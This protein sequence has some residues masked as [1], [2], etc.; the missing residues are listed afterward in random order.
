[1][2]SAAHSRVIFGPDRRLTAVMFAGA[3]L[4]ALA[5]WA[6]AD[7]AGRLLA[8]G[9]ATVLAAYAVTDLLFWPRLCADSTGIV[10]RT[11][12]VRRDLAWEA[13]QAVRV[14]ERSRLGLA[15]RTLEIDAGVMLVVLSRR[16]LGVDPRE[17]LSLLEAFDPG[18]S[19]QP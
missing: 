19:P 12:A 1:M 9:V 2:D 18:G 10:I 17:V 5:G 8:L 14:D 4:A 7:A 3:V 13:V 15:T 16:A 11:P 6:T